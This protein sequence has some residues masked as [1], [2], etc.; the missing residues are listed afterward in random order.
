[1]NEKCCPARTSLFVYNNL[2]MDAHKK[3]FHTPT[4]YYYFYYYNYTTTSAPT[5]STPST[6]TTTKQY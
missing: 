6:T 5:T 2:T 1:M 4:H 3:H